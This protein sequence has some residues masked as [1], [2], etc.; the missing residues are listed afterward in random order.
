MQKAPIFSPEV[1]REI[2]SAMCTPMRSWRTIT[3][4]MSALAAYSIRWL[5]G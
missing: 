5:T 1:T 3:G 4:R 2:A